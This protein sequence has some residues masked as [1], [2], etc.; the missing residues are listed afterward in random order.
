M[1]EIP[2]NPQ[3][4]LL[5]L[6]AV[7][8]DDLRARLRCCPPRTIVST[9]HGSNSSIADMS[10]KYTPSFATR[11]LPKKLVQPNTVTVC[12]VVALLPGGPY[13]IAALP[14]GCTLRSCRARCANTTQPDYVSWQESTS[15][16]AG[17]ATDLA[18]SE[19][20]R[21]AH[22]FRR[23]GQHTLANVADG[24]QAVAR[25]PTAQPGFPGRAFSLLGQ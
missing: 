24:E 8:N 4:P 5:V 1:S 18:L 23:D 12:P 7:R 22:A 2:S 17:E 14:D 3:M 21:Q 15:N 9:C 10:T 19:C 25:T 20:A 13:W 6:V 11:Y 16:H